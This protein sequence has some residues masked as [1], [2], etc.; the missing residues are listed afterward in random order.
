MPTEVDDGWWLRVVLDNGTDGWVQALNVV[1]TGDAEALP[2]SSPDDPAP[3]VLY[4]YG[5]M[6]AF[7]LKTGIGTPACSEA[8]ADGI[9]IQ[10]P[11]GAGEVLFEI[12]QVPIMLGSTAVIRTTES[13]LRIALVEGEAGIGD[14][15]GRRGGIPAGHVGVFELDANG[16][17][18]GDYVV[19]PY[20]DADVANL[21]IALLPRPVEVRSVADIAALRDAPMRDGRW[22]VRHITASITSTG[23][24]AS[25]CD[26][27]TSMLV[28]EL[29]DVDVFVTTNADGTLTITHFFGQTYV[30][31]RDDDGVWRMPPSEIDTGEEETRMTVE[32]EYIFEGDTGSATEITIY[33]ATIGNDFTCTITVPYLVQFVGD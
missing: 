11:D 23:P 10:T 29:T 3:Q 16:D 28:E 14:V 22:I 27:D 32:V 1:V 6:Q 8:P 4:R 9:I 17:A 25:I 15:T 30:Y 18:T 24:G 31:T 19:E 20:T 2:L 12:N 33:S 21:P 26:F 7:R 13:T 5:S